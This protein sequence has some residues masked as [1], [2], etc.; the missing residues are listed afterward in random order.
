[1]GTSDQ[2]DMQEPLRLMLEAVERDD[3]GQIASVQE[4]VHKFLNDANV[5]MMGGWT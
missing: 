3:E 4:R 5:S 2:T 1:M